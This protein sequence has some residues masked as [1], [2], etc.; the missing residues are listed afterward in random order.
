MFGTHDLALF[1]L[2]GFLLN[3][4]PGADCLFI[5]MRSASQGFRAGVAASLGVCSGCFVH[6]MAA[7]LGLSAILATSALAFT[8][9]KLLGAAYL[10][11]IGASLLFRRAVAAPAPSAPAQPASVFRQGFLTNVLNPKMAL[12]FLAFV[13]QFIDPAAPSK[14]L[15]FIFLGTIFTANSAI[16]CLILAWCVSRAALLGMG[17]QAGQWLGRIAGGIFV[18]LGLHLATSR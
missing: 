11:Y 15:A 1:V 13:P 8:L 6:V 3:L 2:S 10:I 4:T 7:A 14:A 16:Y 12:F 9:V 18:A 5:A 17:R